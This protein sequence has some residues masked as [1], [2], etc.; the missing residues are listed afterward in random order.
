MDRGDRGLRDVVE[1][2][3]AGEPAGELV[4]TPRRPHAAHRHLRLVAH[5]PASVEITTAIARKTKSAKS[6]CGLAT[7][8][9]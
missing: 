8:N 3:D 6:S 4:E 1:A 9:V 7:V 5:A 2:G